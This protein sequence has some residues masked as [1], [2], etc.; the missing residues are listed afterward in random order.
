MN[1]RDIYEMGTKYVM[2][3]YG[4]FPIALEKGEGNK[5]WDADG[6][7]YID[8]VGGLAVASLGHCHPEVTQ[9]MYKQS[10][11]LVHTSNL[12]WIKPQVELAKTLVE[13]S[14]FAKVF[15]G[16]SG[17][18]ANEGAIKLARKYS[19][20]KYC[21]ERYEII[22][23]KSS[24]HGRTMATLTA[25]GQEKVQKGF[26]PL[27]EGFKYV[28]FNNIE[29]LKEAVTEKTCAIMLEPV[30]GEGG[31]HVAQKD[32]LQQVEALCKKKDL[33][34]IVDEVQ[35]GVGRTGRL[36]AYQHYGIKPHI[37]TLAKALGNGTAIGAML[38]VEE[39]AGSFQPGDHGSTF[40]GNFLA[41]SAGKKVLEILLR[42]NLCEQVEKM[43]EYF[44]QRLSELKNEFPSIEE[45]RGIGL[46]IGL[47]VKGESLPIVKKAMEKGLLLS[48]AGGNV[49]RFLP[50]LNV[51]KETVDKG[52]EIFKVVM[53]EIE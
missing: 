25:T 12:Y 2:N 50:A 29:A 40:G 9:A 41:C 13:N 1:N 42:D 37:M 39:V 6:K 18:E 7:E 23:M 45:I 20:L 19:N 36:F 33:L 11:E 26:A 30:Q 48:A 38:A 32:Y 8:F 52:L 35:C 27:L 10:G 28:P 46:L 5:V 3:T 51:D 22:T 53:S 21:S 49:V 4:R 24:F 16:N 34:F 14:S 43:G 44:R 47:E 31:V 15:F 17:A